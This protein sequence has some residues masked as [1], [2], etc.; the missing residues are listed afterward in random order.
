MKTIKWRLWVI[1]LLVLFNLVFGWHEL[2]D[3][4]YLTLTFAGMLIACFEGGSLLIQLR[5]EQRQ[6]RLLLERLDEGQRR[7]ETELEKLKRQQ[8]RAII[9]IEQL[10]ANMPAASGVM[11]SDD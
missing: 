11:P 8:V 3:H 1:P 9:L 4:T 6:S 10:V 2:N 5:E 7:S